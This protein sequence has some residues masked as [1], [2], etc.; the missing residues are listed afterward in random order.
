MYT[1]LENSETLP[2]Q[3]KHPIILAKESRVAELIIIDSHIQQLHSG[4]EQT[5]RKI[6]NFF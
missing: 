5:K 1:R 2:E 4:P 3:T 6:R